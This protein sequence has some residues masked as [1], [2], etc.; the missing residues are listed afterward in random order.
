MY[1]LF[2]LLKKNKFLI[3][4][5]WIQ[6]VGSHGWFG[7]R[8]VLTLKVKQTTLLILVKDFLLVEKQGCVI[9]KRHFWY[10]KD[11]F[12][13]FKKYKFLIFVGWIQIFGSHGSF[14]NREVLTL[15]VKQTTFLI[16]LKE[17]LLFEK[18][19]CVIWK[20]HVWYVNFF[21]IYLLYINLYKFLLL[22]EI[23][24]LEICWLN[25]NFWQSWLVWQQEGSNF[26]NTKQYF[27]ANC[28]LRYNNIIIA[29]IFVVTIMITFI[30]VIIFKFTITIIINLR[31][32]FK[33]FQ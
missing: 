22:F 28:L 11:V 14:G 8:E 29:I 7:N 23:Y 15:K 30:N 12:L 1:F 2:L 27:A 26:Q 31:Y 17:F 5:G 13:L 16:L 6:I 21:I 20:I 18:Q 24:I 19:G 25:S 33:W 9:W 4:V 32:P 3:F 10:V